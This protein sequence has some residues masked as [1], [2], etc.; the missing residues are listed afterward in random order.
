MFQF[1][2]GREWSGARAAFWPNP[3]GRC[4]APWRCHES[5]DSLPAATGSGCGSGAGAKPVGGSMISR[6]R[7]KNAPSYAPDI[8]VCRRP[9]ARSP[10]NWPVSQKLSSI[11]S[12]NPFTDVASLSYSGWSNSAARGRRLRRALMVTA[13]KRQQSACRQDTKNEDCNSL[14]VALDWIS[15]AAGSISAPILRLLDVATTQGVIPTTSAETNISARM[16]LMLLK[17]IMFG[18]S[19]P[20]PIA[21]ATSL[22][23]PKPRAFRAG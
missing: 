16:A 22:H 9:A 23:F 2:T 8:F 20:C 13:T 3:G 19:L 11:D 17:L 1:R 14:P 6:C 5:E 18:S 10:A 7:S 4:R 12:N 21:P 15:S